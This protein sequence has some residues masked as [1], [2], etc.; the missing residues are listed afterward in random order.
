MTF[1]SITGEGLRRDTLLI[2]AAL[3]LFQQRIRGIDK[4]SQIVGLNEF[5]ECSRLARSG[6]SPKDCNGIVTFVDPLGDEVLERT[7]MVE[8]ISEPI[9]SLFRSQTCPLNS[10]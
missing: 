10:H 1:Q 9:L 5:M 8:S 2:E 7:C 6:W 3:L 4:E